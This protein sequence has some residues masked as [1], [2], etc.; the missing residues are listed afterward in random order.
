MDPPHISQLAWLLAPVTLPR[1]KRVLSWD[2]W[3]EFCFFGLPLLLRFSLD[4][5]QISSF[6]LE[7][8]ERVVISSSSRPGPLGSFGTPNDLS[9]EKPKCNKNRYKSL[10]FYDFVNQPYFCS[11]VRVF[12]LP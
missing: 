11:F 5:S 10:A 4:S 1:F 12:K 6:V 7:I 8:K 9:T 3:S 2:C